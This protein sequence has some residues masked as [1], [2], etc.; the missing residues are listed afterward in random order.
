MFIK[1]V[2]D[3]QNMK[4]GSPYFLLIDSGCNSGFTKFNKVKITIK[5]FSAICNRISSLPQ[6]SCLANLFIRKSFHI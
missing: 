5:Y 6:N 4:D 1:Y 2:F 3:V